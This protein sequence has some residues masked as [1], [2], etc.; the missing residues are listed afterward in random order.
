[1]DYYHKYTSL[2]MLLIYSNRM[3]LEFDLKSLN[4]PPR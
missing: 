3:Q 4:P 2:D 1:M